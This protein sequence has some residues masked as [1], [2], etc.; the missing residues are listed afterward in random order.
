MCVKT[1]RVWVKGPA[2]R[3]YTSMRLQGFLEQAML[4]KA[5][6]F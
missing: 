6:R 4:F 5:A 1:F 2:S 3:G